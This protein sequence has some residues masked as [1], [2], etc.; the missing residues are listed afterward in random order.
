MNNVELRNIKIELCGEG[1]VGLFTSD[2][3]CCVEENNYILSNVEIIKD[4]KVIKHIG[5][6]GEDLLEG[7][8]EDT[9]GENIEGKAEETVEDT[10]GKKSRWRSRRK[11]R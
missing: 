11:R 9:L 5:E 8:I 6:N 3:D 1:K 10:S 2:E 4:G 7:S